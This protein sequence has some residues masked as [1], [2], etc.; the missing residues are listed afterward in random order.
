M[1]RELPVSAP[2]EIDITRE[3]REPVWDPTLGIPVDTA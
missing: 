3:A 1:L 2:E